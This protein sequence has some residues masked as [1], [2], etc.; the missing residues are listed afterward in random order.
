MIIWKP[1]FAY[2]Q[3]LHALCNAHHFREL[4][5]M[6][7]DYGQ[8]CANEMRLLL[9]IINQ[10]V[11]EHKEAGQ[12]ELPSEL[13]KTFDTAYDSIFKTALSQIPAIKVT[14]KPGKRGRTKQHPA[15]FL[16]DRLTLKKAETL[17]F[18]HDFNVPFTN[19]Q[20]ERDIR[21]AKV[22]QKVSGCFRSEEGAKRFCRIR[23]Y[24]STPQK[25][26]INVLLALEKAIRGHPEVFLS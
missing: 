5:A 4:R 1:Y 3:S 9:S 25:R 19:N 11:T 6:H 26:D 8:I 24:I 18:M 22:R 14:K 10:T 21:M 13:L 7:E 16:P 20:A 15:N 12:L 23:G 2:D 17:R